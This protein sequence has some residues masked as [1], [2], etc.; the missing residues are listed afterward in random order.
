MF[1]NAIAFRFIGSRQL[2]MTL[3]L[4]CESWFKKTKFEY[5]LQQSVCSSF[6]TLQQKHLGKMCMR[7]IKQG[8]FIDNNRNVKPTWL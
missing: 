3:M 5:K 6:E 7:N 8:G 2:S 4:H 1:N